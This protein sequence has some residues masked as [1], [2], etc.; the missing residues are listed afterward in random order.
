MARLAAAIMHGLQVAVAARAKETC[1]WQRNG[2]THARQ[3][4]RN[5]GPNDRAQG[6]E[7]A[8]CIVR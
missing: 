8:L 4:V 2:L 5:R 7:G 6:Q 1:V 3:A